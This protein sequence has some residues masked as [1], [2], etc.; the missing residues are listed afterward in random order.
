MPVKDRAMSPDDGGE[1]P[2]DRRSP[3]GKPVVRGDRTV[4]GDRAREAV[5]FDPTDPAS[6]ETAAETV[7]A[8]ANGT[9]DEEDQIAMLRGAAAC[10]ALVLGEGSYKAAAERAGAGVSVSFIRK[11]ARVHDLPQSIRRH[12]ARGEIA[13]T[14]AKHIARV[15]GEDRY[16]LAWA[17]LDHGLTVREIRAV[18]SEVNDGEDVGNALGSRGYTVG[19]LTM[20][21]PPAI[22]R[23][24][25]RVAA[26]DGVDPGAIVADAL[27]GYL[28]ENRDPESAP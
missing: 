27:E 22:Y 14:A 9:I 18:A 11:W 17:A 15:T 8:F 3:V 7:G 12:V 16:L 25:R 13:P 19:E 1:V 28:A 6:L 4:T 20:Q 24:L 23:D 26:Y 10:A 5:K 21:L 2:S